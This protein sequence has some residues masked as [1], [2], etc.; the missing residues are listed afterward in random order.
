[1]GMFADIEGS[2]IP[3]AAPAISAWWIEYPAFINRN[4]RVTPNIRV[5]I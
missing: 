3:V 1:M 2:F 5:M 4:N